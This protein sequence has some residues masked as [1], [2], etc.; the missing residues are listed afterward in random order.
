MKRGYLLEIIGIVILVALC[1]TLAI[2][3]LNK[4]IVGNPIVDFTSPLPA[5]SPQPSISPPEYFSTQKICQLYT[6]PPTPKDCN[7]YAEPKTTPKP[8]D[9]CPIL[10]DP[11][12]DTKFDF[13]FIEPFDDK[14]KYRIE[15]DYLN[16]FKY[17]E[18][19]L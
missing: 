5:I 14:L 18:R 17:Y 19:F 11:S 12:S 16:N 15:E 1:L 8:M 13:Q 10:S 9:K 7:T 2:T 6:P 4:K 3:G